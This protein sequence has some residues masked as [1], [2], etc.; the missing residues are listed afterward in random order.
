MKQNGFTKSV[1]FTF[2]LISSLFVKNASAQGTFTCRWSDS[3]IVD[4]IDCE[5]G[6]VPNYET[7]SQMDIYP[8]QTSGSFNCVLPEAAPTSALQ[9]EE[10]YDDIQYYDTALFDMTDP[11]GS[12]I[13][14]FLTYLFP[15]AGLLLLL[16]LIYGGYN[17]MLSG[18]DPK[19]AASA[20]S[21]ITTALFGFVIIFVAYWLVQILGSVFGL[22]FST[23]F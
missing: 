23:I 3:C 5:S 17:L 21:I 4:E 22:G 18:G 6:Y 13:N 20:K 14:A 7:C 9:L 16:Y 8:C 12:I 10:L 15:F 2:F 19:K 1:I 11:L